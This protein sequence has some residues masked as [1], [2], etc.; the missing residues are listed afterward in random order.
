[1]EK[2]KQ[3]HP[4]SGIW[5]ALFVSAGILGVMTLLVILTANAGLS[6]F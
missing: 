3:Y 4:F 1:M 6:S 2:M 5:T